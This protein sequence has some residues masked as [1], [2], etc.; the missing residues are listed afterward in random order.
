MNYLKIKNIK[1][2]Y[3][4]FVFLI[5]LESVAD[6]DID[7]SLDV[8][9]SIT[10]QITKNTTGENL[11]TN[12]DPSQNGKLTDALRVS[13]DLVTNSVSA[14]D[15]DFYI[16]AKVASDGGGSVD[17]FA[18]YDSKLILMLGNDTLKP[19][20]SEI[21]KAAIGDYSKYVVAYNTNLDLSNIGSNT[22][23]TKTISSDY[24]PCYLIKAYSSDTNPASGALTFSVAGMPVGNTY[25]LSTIPPGE[26]KAVVTITAQPKR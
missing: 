3:F 26:Y 8:D 4:L 20:A 6:A 22:I 11:N 17:A 5:G 16:S 14:D 2:F 23:M 15:F 21:A 1:I 18:E 19:S 25:T 7:V 9:T 24:G 10:A 12:I 13:Y